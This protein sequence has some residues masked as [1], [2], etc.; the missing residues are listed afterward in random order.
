VL[1]IFGRSSRPFCNRVSQLDVLRIGS[2]GIVGLTLADL[3]RS[4]AVAS[5][6]GGKAKSIINVI[7]SGG[8]SHIDTFDMKLDAPREIRG[9]FEPIRTNL[10]GVQICEHL[11]RL[12]QNLNSSK[13]RSA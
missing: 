11:P 9:S 8:L 4:N 1:S 7:L 2:A 5:A 6:K 13:S 12:A 10:P 3:L